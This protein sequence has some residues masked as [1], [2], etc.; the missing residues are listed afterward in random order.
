VGVRWLPRSE[1]SERSWSRWG[2]ALPLYPASHRVVLVGQE[3]VS[4]QDPSVLRARHPH[5][6]VVAL[7]GRDR[8]ERSDR[9]REGPQPCPC[10]V[11]LARQGLS[12]QNRH[13]PPLSICRPAQGTSR[14][15]PLLSPPS[16]VFA[17]TTSTLPN[18]PDHVVSWA[19][20]PRR[21]R[22]LGLVDC[23]L[24]GHSAERGSLRRGGRGPRWVVRS[25]C[26][27]AAAQRCTA[28]PGPPEGR[29]TVVT[30]PRV[31]SAA[32]G[33]AALRTRDTRTENLIEDP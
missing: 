8:V 9:I 7:R 12:T 3:A 26:G 6:R 21:R 31:C 14:L 17:G 25:L 1:S 27:Q 16:P 4:K 15:W 5:E 23:R 10:R 13:R 19:A 29:T 30:V 22:L 28:D 11:V 18:E 2:Q 20:S 32:R 24:R 33:C